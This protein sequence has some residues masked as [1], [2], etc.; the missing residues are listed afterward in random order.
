M[1]HFRSI[2]K[3]LSTDLNNWLCNVYIEVGEMN[4][5]VDKKRGQTRLDQRRGEQ[6]RGD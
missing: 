3:A 6:I 1:E 5:R 2:E 4:R